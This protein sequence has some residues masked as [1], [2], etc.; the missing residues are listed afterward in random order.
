MTTTLVRAARSQP[1][2]RTPVW[3]MRQ[4]GRSLPEYRELRQGNQMLE[5]CRTPDLVTEITLQPVRRHN[6]DAAIFFSDI[7]VP[8]QA[9]GIDVVIEPGVGPVI[10]HPVR[11]QADID[12]LP[13]LTAEMMPDIT[14]S[15]SR[16]AAELTT[17]EDTALIGF[18]GAPF[19]LASYLIEGGPSR[20]H[21]KTKAMMA[22]APEMFSQLLAKLAA[23]STTFIDVQLSAGAQAFQLFD[24]WAGY[25]SP[26]DYRTHVLPHSQ[27]VFSDL[28]HHD[29]PSIHFGVQTGELLPAMS[30]AGSNVVGADFRVELTDAATRIK[31]GQALQ[32][33]LDPALLFAPWEALQP[34]IEQ[35]VRD[36]LAHSGGHIFNLGHGVLPATDPEVPGRI[37]D[38]V[39][40]ISAALLSGD[41]P[42]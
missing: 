31:P 18:A 26:R 20:N 8:L 40:R 14:E 29:V 25:L 32:G 22:G 37:V 9:A 42:K 41:D 7:V 23:M 5:A 38:E 12:N 28:A 16:I 11:T 3:F 13:E 35:I 4:A 24:S 21:E 6:V 39:H 30:E 15:I 34:R 19:T 36:G 2:D 33:N 1:V 10:A 27:R 17:R